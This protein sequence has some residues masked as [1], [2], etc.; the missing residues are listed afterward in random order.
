MD[1]VRTSAKLPGMALALAL[2]VPVSD[3]HAQGAA[4]EWKESHQGSYVY[5]V[6]CPQGATDLKP[7]AVA[8][9]VYRRDT[10]YYKIGNPGTGWMFYKPMQSDPTSSTG[11]YVQTGACPPQPDG[12]IPYGCPTGYIAN[13]PSGRGR[14]EPVGRCDLDAV[15]GAYDRILADATR[16][17]AQ[18]PDFTPYYATQMFE[19]QLVLNACKKQYEG[20][21]PRDERTRPYPS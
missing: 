3:G 6:A 15:K 14:W 2:A 16:L 10:F 13:D 12:Q 19:A 4:I 5:W 17:M 8:L 20:V 9:P 21:L 7:C 18:S 11:I 1:P